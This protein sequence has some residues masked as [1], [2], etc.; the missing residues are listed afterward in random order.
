MASSF[1]RSDPGSVRLLRLRFV[2]EL[3][4]GDRVSYQVK[5]FVKR[6]G[7]VPSIGI[8]ELRGDL[9]YSAVNRP[10]LTEGPP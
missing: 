7:R 10:K 6:L 5:R 3:K 9:F 4:L 8:L 2:E 1:P